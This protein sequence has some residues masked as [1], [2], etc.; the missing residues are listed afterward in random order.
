MH[1]TSIINELEQKKKK[2]FHLI[3]QLLTYT[4]VFILDNYNYI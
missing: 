3:I 4:T 2:L 1:W